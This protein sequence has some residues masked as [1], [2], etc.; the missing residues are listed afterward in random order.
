MFKPMFVPPRHNNLVCRITDA[1]LPHL[2]Q[3]LAN[4]KDVQLAPDDLE[5]LK[6]L[7]SGRAILAPNHPTGLDPLVLYWVSR[8]L[9]E[10]FHYLAARE[11][12]EGWKGWYLNQLGA[13]SVVRGIADRES[14]RT[15]RRL[16]AEQDRKIVIFPEGEIYEH[17]DALLAFQPGVAQLGFWALDDVAK[18]KKPLSLPLV[19]VAF[20]YRC[21]DSP[22]PAIEN[23]LKALENGLDLSPAS[24]LTAYQRLRRI[25]DAMLVSVEKEI[26]IT[27]DPEKPLTERIK[28]Y[29]AKFLSRVARS[30]GAELDPEMT[31]AEQLHDLF[32]ELRAWVGELPDD[33]NEYDLRRFRRR[34]EIAEP[35]FGEL[36][37]FQNFIAVTGDYILTLPT[38]ERFLEVLGRLEK[39]VFGEI[40]HSVPREAVV[41]IGTPIRLEERYTAYRESRRETVK[42]VTVELEEQIRAMLQELSETGTPLSM[43]F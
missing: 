4:I 28:T 33:H 17:N 27:P 6:G 1:V 13:Y 31:P 16:L 19:P 38:A 34:L 42:Q 7:G 40:Q 32:N 43:E 41:R 37:R 22:R 3:S 20:K 8:T 25:G 5:R 24:R 29:R 26:G 39:E 12:L 36:Q 15:T 18:L 14:I 10:R 21:S 23:S 35:L 2:A 30:I 11:V 9:G